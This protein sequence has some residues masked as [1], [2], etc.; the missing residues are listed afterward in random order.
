MI[1][2][3]RGKEIS[4]KKNKFCGYYRDTWKCG[5]YHNIQQK[6]EGKDYGT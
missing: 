3:S 1:L 6:K 5:G 2:N 4:R